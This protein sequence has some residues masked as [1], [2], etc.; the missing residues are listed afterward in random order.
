MANGNFE[1]STP[2][3]NNQYNDLQPD[4]YKYQFT[5]ELLFEFFGMYIFITLSLGN[6]AIYALFPEA[7]LT[8]TSIAV[9]W[10]FNLTFGL[11]LANLSS[12]AHL[13]PVVSLCAF[14]FEKTLNIVEF[15]LY[16]LIQFLAAFFASLTVYI[17][18]YNNLK[19]GDAYSG[20]FTTY[21]NASV[22][23]GLAFFTELCGTAL[24]VSGIF[25]LCNF[26]KKKLYI[27]MYI[28]FWLST[29]ILSFGYQTAFA[30]NPARDFG[31]RVLAAIVGYSSFTYMDNYWWI[32]LVADYLGGIIGYFIYYTIK[33]LQLLEE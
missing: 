23:P 29:L 12:K 32:P 4:T 19:D 25:T 24:L 7:R 8:W 22:S 28:G 9:S 16:S 6:V 26:T 2:N 10:G 21:R 18:Y 17:V 33:Y 1:L 13:N 3:E 31:P 20:V 11:Y 30:W 5:K 14:L 27:P 15:L